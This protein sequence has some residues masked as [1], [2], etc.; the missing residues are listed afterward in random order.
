MAV[1]GGGGAHGGAVGW[2]NVLQAGRSRLR[3]PGST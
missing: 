3:L 1:N 2:G